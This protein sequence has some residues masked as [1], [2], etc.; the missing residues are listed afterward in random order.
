MGLNRGLYRKFAVHRIDGEDL[1]GRSKDKAKYF[2][3]DVVNDPH[4]RVAL[5]AYI[6]SLAIDFPEYSKLAEDLTE[7]LRSTRNGDNS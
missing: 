3:L 4:A 5:Q 2:V 6:D 7:L 1:P